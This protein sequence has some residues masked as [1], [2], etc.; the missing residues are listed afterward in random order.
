MP[1]GVGRR[2]HDG[3][4]VV[5]ESNRLVYIFAV[6]AAAVAIGFCPTHDDFEAHLAAAAAHPSGYLGT[7]IAIADKLRISLG[8]ESKSYLILRT[9]MYCRCEAIK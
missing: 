9:G 2:L 6:A 8:A 3:A 4:E 5:P 1:Q 7:V